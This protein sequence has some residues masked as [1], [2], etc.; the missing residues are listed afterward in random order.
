MTEAL[1]STQWEKVRS[2][3]KELEK[4]VDYFKIKLRVTNEKP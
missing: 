4:L 1:R 2:R 3:K